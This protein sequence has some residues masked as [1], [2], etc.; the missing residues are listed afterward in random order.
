MEIE[1]FVSEKELEEFPEEAPDSSGT[2]QQ[3]SMTSPLQGTVESLLSVD[4]SPTPE[5][6]DR[7][8]KG[9]IAHLVG[10][11]PSLKGL[12]EKVLW[13]SKLKLAM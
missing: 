3:S 7:I 4:T 5:L 9:E 6:L 12:I 10:C 1:L 8:R 11:T 2:P 13:Q